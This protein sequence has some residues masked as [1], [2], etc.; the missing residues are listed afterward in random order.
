MGPRPGPFP[1]TCS[2]ACDRVS[3]YCNLLRSW[4][5]EALKSSPSPSGP[6]SLRGQ[7]EGSHPLLPRS[8]PPHPST[9]QVHFTSASVTRLLLSAT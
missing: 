7:P 3:P 5:L 1:S 8:S 2:P 9:L 6:I 4:S